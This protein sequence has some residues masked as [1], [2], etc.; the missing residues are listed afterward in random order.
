MYGILV[1]GGGIVVLEWGSGMPTFIHSLYADGGVIAANPSPHGGTWAWCAIAKA[2]DED[3]IAIHGMGIIRPGD[4]GIELPA[5]TNNVSE[6]V[7]VVAGLESMPDGWAGRLYSDSRITLGRLFE[8]YK[9]NGI[10]EPLKVRARKAMAHVHWR[11]ITPIHLDGHPTKAQL[12]VGIGK[13]GNLVS[14][15]NAWCDEQCTKQARLHLGLW[16]KA[17]L[18]AAGGSGDRKLAEVDSDTIGSNG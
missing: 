18:E 13:R 6:M 16:N 9:W 7:A 1:F 12:E 15:W 2:N 17:Q 3:Y 4:K 11:A 14:K 8:G 5:I 10:P